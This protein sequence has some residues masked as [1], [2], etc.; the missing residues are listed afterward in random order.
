M[1]CS[2][3]QEMHNN[4]RGLFEKLIRPLIGVDSRIVDASKK[5]KLMPTIGSFVP[6][7]F[8]LVTK[9]HVLSVGHCSDIELEEVNQ[10]ID[11]LVTSLS[12]LYNCPCVVF[13][14]GC[15]NNYNRGG[16]CVDHAHIH[17][18][19]FDGDII[20]NID[21]N[22]NVEVVNDIGASRD[23]ILDGK[24]YIYVQDNKLVRYIVSGKIIPSQYIRQIIACQL[25]IPDKWDWRLHYGEENMKRSLLDMER[26]SFRTGVFD[27]NEEGGNE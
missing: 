27:I 6:G 10:L 2:F 5:W 26:L 22:L 24:S 11:Q 9:R 3:C 4:N 21:G 8:L 15:Y 14:H 16:C 1:S 20:A 7:Y 23:Y 18:L 19:P 17:I 12:A 13:E 25:G